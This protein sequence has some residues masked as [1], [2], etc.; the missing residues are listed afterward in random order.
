VGANPF[1]GDAC[2]CLSAAACWTR[3]RGGDGRINA[4][5]C[6]TY[7]VRATLEGLSGGK[8]ILTSERRARFLH[9]LLH[10][11]NLISR[12]REDVVW[13]PGAL[14]G[15]EPSRGGCE[16]RGDFGEEAFGA[17]ARRGTAGRGLAG[18]A[19]RT[20]AAVERMIE[21]E[22][23]VTLGGRGVRLGQGLYGRPEFSGGIAL[24]SRGAGRID[25]TL[26]LV[27]LLVWRLGTRAGSKGDR[28]R[29]DL[30]CTSYGEHRRQYTQRARRVHGSDRVTC[31]QPGT[32]NG[33]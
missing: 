24:G 27:H 12:P 7:C 25:G 18:G 26:R 16:C 32:R 11:R 2:L 31:T 1:G 19:L 9:G 23:V 10:S 22:A 33:R 3:R 4:G 20:L 21:R 29:Q 14:R 13:E 17:A 8:I 15:V 30:S 5:D 6:G 28:E